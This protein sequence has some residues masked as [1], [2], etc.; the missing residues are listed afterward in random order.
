MTLMLVP[1]IITSGRQ[2]AIQKLLD[3]PY[4]RVEKYATSASNSKTLCVRPEGGKCDAMVYGSLL[5]SLYSLQLWSRKSSREINMSVNDLISKLKSVK[6]MKQH[7]TYN[8]TCDYGGMDRYM[9]DLTQT[10]Q[11]IASWSRRVQIYSELKS[12]ENREYRTMQLCMCVV[13]NGALYTIW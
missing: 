6:I 3:V 5:I 12:P 8:I 13:Q 9:A 2:S 11:S 7:S 4:S 10:A 1:E